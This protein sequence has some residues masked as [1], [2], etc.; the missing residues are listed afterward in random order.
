MLT[1]RHWLRALLAAAFILISAP[2]LLA[3]TVRQMN[4]AE[5]VE[6]ADKI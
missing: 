6:R 5:M 3:D 4:H 1:S 2:A